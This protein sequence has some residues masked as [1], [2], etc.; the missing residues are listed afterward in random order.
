MAEEN[1]W[2][3]DTAPPAQAPAKR[4]AL[5]GKDEKMQKLNLLVLSLQ[6]A[7]AARQLSAATWWTVLITAGLGK[8]ALETTRKHAEAT[9]GQTNHK[10]GWPHIQLWRTLIVQLMA[11]TPGNAETEAEHKI[12]AAYLKEFE[13]AGPTQGY[14]FVTQARL[15]VVKDPA[16][17][18]LFYSLSELMQPAHKWAIDAAIHKLSLHTKSE[19]KPGTAPPSE[20]EK[21]IHCITH[22]DVPY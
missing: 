13:A 20:V 19:I 2:I 4:I 12:V 3:T 18:V 1:G 11:M 6:N 10:M 15:K 21:K 16:N 5:E 17:M 22:T 7:Q 9:R 14:K 8:H